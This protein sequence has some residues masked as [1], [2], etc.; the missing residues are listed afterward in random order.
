M[1]IIDI[2]IVLN[3]VYGNNGS[4]DDSEPEYNIYWNGRGLVS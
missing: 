2:Q 1:H 3:G 4:L